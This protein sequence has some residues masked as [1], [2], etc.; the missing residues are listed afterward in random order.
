MTMSSGSSYSSN[1][2]KDDNYGQG[3]WQY[4]SYNDP[5]QPTQDGM[6]TQPS[7]GRFTEQGKAATMF[8]K[9]PATPTLAPPKDSSSPPGS[10]G[11][12]DLRGAPRAEGKMNK[13]SSKGK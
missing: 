2:K 11:I 3:G 12:V 10:G 4:S 7:V 9:K 8:V 5:Q 6:T 13:N 1:N